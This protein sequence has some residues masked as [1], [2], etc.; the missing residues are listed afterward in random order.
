M[1][2][3]M[4]DFPYFTKYKG[5]FCEESSISR[6]S[7]VSSSDWKMGTAMTTIGLYSRVAPRH[8]CSWRARARIFSVSNSDRREENIFFFQLSTSINR[9]V[10]LGGVC[11]CVFLLEGKKAT[12]KNYISQLKTRKKRKLSRD[13]EEEKKK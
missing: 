12:K 6:D 3:K 5:T 7:C 2:V 1:R 11:V 10:S 8:K 4:S 9:A 13:K